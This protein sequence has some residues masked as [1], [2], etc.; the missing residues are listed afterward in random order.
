MSSATTCSSALLLVSAHVS[1]S[2]CRQYGLMSV[3]RDL[4]PSTAVLIQLH[5]RQSLTTLTACSGSVPAHERQ[6]M[7]W[8]IAAY[9]R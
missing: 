5:P 6:M 1:G 2:S 9:C 7:Q 8:V 3:Q 4:R